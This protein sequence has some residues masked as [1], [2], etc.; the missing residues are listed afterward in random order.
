MLAGPEAIKPKKRK[1]IF[2]LFPFEKSMHWKGLFLVFLLASTACVA[3]FLD[4][5]WERIEVPE[6]RYSNV[7]SKSL[8]LLSAFTLWL[9]L[10]EIN[11][12]RCCYHHHIS[13]WNC[14]LAISTFAM[15]QYDEGY[16]E[17]KSLFFEKTIN[18]IWWLEPKFCGKVALR[19]TFSKEIRF[20][21]ELFK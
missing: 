19:F 8:L 11:R 10:V 9:V 16:R 5:C 18:E 7:Y 4:D 21:C 14:N 1:S 15:L 12:L 3:N 17:G 20:D 13:I 2:F 6:P